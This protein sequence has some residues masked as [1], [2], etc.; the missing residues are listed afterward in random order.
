VTR[1]PKAGS[2]GTW[3]IVPAFNEAQAIASVLADLRRT[4]HQIVVVDDGSTDATADFAMQADAT[5]VR[6]PIN[7]G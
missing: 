6:H 1:R 2:C 4:G 3:V 7:L 5:V